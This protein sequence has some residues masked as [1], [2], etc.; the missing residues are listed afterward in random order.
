MQ[1]KL[2]NDIDTYLLILAKILILIEIFLFFVKQLWL[3]TWIPP[4]EVLIIEDCAVFWLERKMGPV[5]Q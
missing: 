4:V 1:G 2:H 3:K 5:V